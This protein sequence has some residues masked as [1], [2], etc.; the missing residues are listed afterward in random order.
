MYGA[1]PPP[2]I[3]P[4]PTTMPMADDTSPAG[5][6]S[7]AMGPVI[8]AT[9]PRQ[10]NEHTNSAVN[11][12]VRPALVLANHHT[13]RAAPA[14]PMIASGLR[15]KRSDNPGQPNWPK[16]PPKPMADVTRPMSAG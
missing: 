10:K 9:L 11:N 13:A 2:K 15:P 16:K 6:D 12:G 14:K 1:A 7:V 8:N 4:A 5:A 3:S